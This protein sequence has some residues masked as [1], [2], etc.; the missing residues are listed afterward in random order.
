ML[1]EIAQ[2]TA[3]NI[4]AKKAQE[5]VKGSRF[6]SKMPLKKGAPVKKSNLVPP[7]KVKAPEIIPTTPVVKQIDP[8]LAEA[9]EKQQ[10]QLTRQWGEQADLKLDRLMK[11]LKQRKLTSAQHSALKDRFKLISKSSAPP[12]VPEDSPE[13][14]KTPTRPIQFEIDWDAHEPGGRLEFL[15]EHEM[16][17]NMLAE[18]VITVIEENQEDHLRMEEFLAQNH[19]IPTVAR[20]AIIAATPEARLE[21]LKQSIKSRLVERTY[22]DD[23]NAKIQAIDAE[24]QKKIDEANAKLKEKLAKVPKKSEPNFVSPPMASDLLKDV[25][26]LKDR[27]FRLY[28][29]ALER[30][31]D[32]IGWQRP[33]RMEN[34]LAKINRYYEISQQEQDDLDRLQEI[35]DGPID[36]DQVD[37]GE[38][39]EDLVNKVQKTI[40]ILN[41]SSDILESV[42]L[43][44][45]DDEKVRQIAVFLNEKNEKSAEKL[46]KMTTDFINEV[47]SLSNYNLKRKSVLTRIEVPK[48]LEQTFYKP[49]QVVPR[50]DHLEKNVDPLLDDGEIQRSPVKR[51]QQRLQKD[52][53]ATSN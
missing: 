22:I 48:V 51:N 40:E 7:P 8:E 27:P 3:A 49:L 42:F 30:F 53:Q 9:V 21:K 45:P 11:N 28:T 12:K 47:W 4:A 15:Q 43:E 16:N 14:E 1:E 2:K 26:T 41:E 38:F 39:G 37:L 18:A 33:D 52:M 35:D 31:D 24:K 36:L 10:E 44:F 34:E 6:N 17:D 46:Q 19:E 13:H 23:R 29:P 5:T 20:E 25:E 32:Y 50:S